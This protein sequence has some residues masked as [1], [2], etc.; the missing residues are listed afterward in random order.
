M[1]KWSK[2]G[3][4][5]QS[6]APQNCSAARLPRQRGVPS[7]K[8]IVGGTRIR[9]RTVLRSFPNWLTQ[10]DRQAD[11]RFDGFLLWLR[12]G[13]G[14]GARRCINSLQ[15]LVC[16]TGYCHDTVIEVLCA[17]RRPKLCSL[18]NTGLALVSVSAFLVSFI[19]VSIIWRIL[20]TVVGSGRCLL[21]GGAYG[22]Y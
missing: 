8:S 7:P 5:R 15:L 11:A 19:S 10:T 3:S 9:L 20:F 4:K 21:T 14:W 1:Q 22:D 2:R 13:L 6:G 18:I 16:E 12:P 17:H